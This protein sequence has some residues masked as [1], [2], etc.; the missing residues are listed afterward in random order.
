MTTN[1]MRVERRKLWEQMKSMLDTAEKEKRKFTAEEDAK[2]A[3]L[4][5]DLDG[6]KEKIDTEEKA[7]QRKAKMGEV[8][9][10]FAQHTTERVDL[11][12]TNGSASEGIEKRA[13]RKFLLDGE[14]SLSV[15]EK[16]A[17]DMGVDSSGGYTV[18]PQ[19]FVNSLIK[20]VDNQT[21]MRG[22]ST[23]YSVTSS[24]SLGAPALDANPADPT[25]TSE[26]LIGSEDST[27]A[28]GKRELRPHPLAQ[29]IKVSKKLLRASALGVESLIRDRLAY[30][31]A[32]V[33]ENAY[34]NGDGSNEPLGVFA[35]PAGFGI[36]TDRDISTGNT[37]TAIGADGLI[38]AK[39]HLKSQ[40]W[41]PAR[42]LFSRE[43]VK[44]IRKLKDGEGQY[45]W[46]AG[47]SGDRGDSILDV[48]VLMSEYVPHVFTTGLYVGII[49]DFSKYWIADALGME[50][51]VLTELY[52]ATNQNGYILRAESDGMPVL[53]EAFARV[54]LA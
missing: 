16:R 29:Y 23:V 2:Y 33:M 51:Q 28:F 36:T 14:R 3:K 15:D 4:E 17:L 24:E 32:V 10:E 11:G 1:D 40:Y 47:I 18:L 30:K 21:F 43:A 7:E 38:E 5:T 27:M 6:L 13:L 46:R 53:E 49:G 8:E 31:A 44:N 52:A 54:T 42:W 41:A 12:E 48:P 50:I 35:A 20:A 19:Q 26:I 34:L 25:W 22:L 37:D 9:Q 39:Y 45:L